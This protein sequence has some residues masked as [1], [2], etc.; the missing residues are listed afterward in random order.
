MFCVLGRRYDKDGKYFP[1][2]EE[3]LWTQKLIF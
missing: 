1:D 2:N 3:G